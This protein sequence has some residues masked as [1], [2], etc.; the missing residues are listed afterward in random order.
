[1]SATFFTLCLFSAGLSFLL[2]KKCLDGKVHLLCFAVESNNLSFDFFAYAEN[3]CGSFNSLMADLGY[4]YKTV[5]ALF[6]LYECAERYNPYDLALYDV[7]YV[8]LVSGKLPRLGLKLLVADGNLLVFPVN[9]ENLEVIYAADLK[10]VGYFLGA[11][12][13]EVGD[14][15]KT[16]ETAYGYECTERGCPFYLAFY[17]VAF[18]N[19]VEEFLLL[20]FLSGSPCIALFL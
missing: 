15:R 17:D 10:H 1:M 4:V 6:N 11:R 2:G 20:C 9:L 18:G 8:I 3:G 16:I 13:A 12:P 5:D 19:S 14:V 7:A